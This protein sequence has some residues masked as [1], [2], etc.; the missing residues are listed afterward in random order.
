VSSHAYDHV[1][2]FVLLRSAILGLALLVSRSATAPPL[3]ASGSHFS[4]RPI[5]APLPL[6]PYSFCLGSFHFAP[7]VSFPPRRRSPQDPVL[8]CGKSLPRHPFRRLQTQPTH[9][10]ERTTTLS[11]DPETH[12]PRTGPRPRIPLRSTPELQSH[13][14]SRTLRR[15]AHGCPA[16]CHTLSSSPR[17][18]APR[19][20]LT[21]QRISGGQPRAASPAPPNRGAIF[22]P[23]RSTLSLC[24][25]VLAIDPPQALCSN[26]H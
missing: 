19:T 3:P 21:P 14:G 25:R 24:P 6:D 10:P 15:H 18:T 20:P 12:S 23:S 4:T 7:M 17:L 13:A 22:W 11:L 26:P 1:H 9:H 16:S 2:F 8:F 5:R